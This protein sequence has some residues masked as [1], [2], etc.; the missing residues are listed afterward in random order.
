MENQ[1]L[2]FL[3]KVTV[4]IRISGASPPWTGFEPA[5]NGLTGGNTE[6]L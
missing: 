5:T 6:V 4:D 3:A 1:N 2:G